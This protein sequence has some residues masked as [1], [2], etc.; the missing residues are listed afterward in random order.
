MKTMEEEIELMEIREE[1]V[2]PNGRRSTNIPANI[3][4]F[5]QFKGRLECL[6]FVAKIQGE[7]NC[8]CG[9]N[10]ASHDKDT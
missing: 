7:D 4:A 6:G 9:R 5:E 1:E 3:P 2:E 8:W 10:R